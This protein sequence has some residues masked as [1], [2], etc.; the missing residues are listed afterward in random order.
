[1]RRLIALVA[2]APGRLAVSAA[3]L[4]TVALTAAGHFPELVVGAVYVVAWS[5]I[6]AVGFLLLAVAGNMAGV[7]DDRPTQPQQ[8]GGPH[9]QG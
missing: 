8:K 4:A 1:M 5:T 9:A 7:Y 3:C 2:G 6:F